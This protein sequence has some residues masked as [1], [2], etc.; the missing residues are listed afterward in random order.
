MRDRII[1]YFQDKG[2]IPPTFHG[3]GSFKVHTCINQSDEDYDIDDSVYLQHIP[4]HK[5]DWPTTETVHGEILEAVKGHTDIPPKDKHSCVRVQYKNE[6]HVDLAIYG[7]DGKVYLAR[8]GAEQWEENNPKLFTEWF[9]NK[10]AIYGEQLRNICKYLK[11]WSYYNGWNDT[12]T[13]F[14]I[15]ILVGNHFSASPDREDLALYNTLKGIVSYLQSNRNIIRPVE[16]MKDMTESLTDKEMDDIISHLK[17]FRDDAQKAI[18]GASK[19]DAHQTWRQLF[20][21]DFPKYKGNQN[22]NSST[23]STIIREN[24][25]WGN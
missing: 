10:L 2:W 11:K 22:G 17:D 25:P 15:T 13:G 24:K 3:Q 5:K 7:E 8:K 6:Y 12:I 20:G 21:D 19:E 16:P 14:Y 1:G 4:E 9:L 23:T 18:M